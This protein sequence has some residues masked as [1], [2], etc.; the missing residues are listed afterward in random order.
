MLS[1]CAGFEPFGLGGLSR[2]FL[3]W[4]AGCGV[5]GGGADQGTGDAGFAELGLWHVDGLA[6]EDECTQQGS[7]QHHN[8]RK[9][10]KSS[11]FVVHG[12]F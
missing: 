12:C 3:L 4:F 10:K 8:Q 1:L 9:D 11:G 2:F 6:G 5:D 7:M